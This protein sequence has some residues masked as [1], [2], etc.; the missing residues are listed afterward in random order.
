MGKNMDYLADG[1]RK[2]DY[3]P[4]LQARQ[5]DIHTHKTQKDVIGHQRHLVWQ[6]GSTAQ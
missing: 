5:T 1:V 4:N 2:A 6:K 3:N